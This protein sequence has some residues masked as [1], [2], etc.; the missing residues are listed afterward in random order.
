MICFIFSTF[1][2]EFVSFSF[3]LIKLLKMF[4]NQSVSCQN[5]TNYAN[6]PL[7]DKSLKPLKFEV[8]TSVLFGNLGE[9]RAD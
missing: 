2:P 3:I 6:V 9:K 8:S 4:P 7:A 5:A 1:E